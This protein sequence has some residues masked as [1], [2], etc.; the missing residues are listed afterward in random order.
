MG[1]ETWAVLVWG[2]VFLGGL[3]A[4]LGWL[5]ALASRRSSRR[6][7]AVIEELDAVGAGRPVAQHPIVEEA[8]CIGCGSCIAACPED[9][10][11]GLVD[12]IAHIIHGSHCVGHGRCAEACPVGAI[13]LG[14][15]DLSARPDLPVLSKEL[16]SSLPGIFLAGELGGL[17]LIRNAVR[18][19]ELAALAAA[20][21]A[22]T[23]RR[24]A[25]GPEA[26]D[27][28][29]VGAGPAG[30]TA[31]LKARELG[32]STLVLEQEEAGGTMRKYPRRKLVLTQPV[33]IPGLGELTRPEYSKEELLDLW[34]KALRREAL[35]I[36]ERVRLTGISGSAGAFTVRTSVGDYSARTVILALGRRGTPRRLGVPGEE[37]DK[38]FYQLIDAASY[39]GEHLLVVGGGDSAVEAAMALANQR[40]NTVTLSYRKPAFQRIKRRNAERIAEYQ[41]G[42][43]VEVIFSS[44][45]ER[46]EAD[47]VLL[48][49]EGED[50][51]REIPN[52]QVFIFAGGDPPFP[53]LREIGIRFGGD[54]EPRRA[55]SPV[56]SA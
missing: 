27:I 23:S 4:V 53:L 18:Q 34:E 29:V 22:A 37:L 56:V 35:P 40:G 1:D 13:T 9:D 2:A 25:P 54:S 41:G 55:A 21:R 48:R 8:R 45:V 20:R 30:L 32:A 12:G 31:A 47:S 33:K 7:R 11:L 36:L 14:L 43:R 17:A 3:L 44:Q 51:V 39:V 19:G 38:V 52:Q 46:I 28:L 49:V 26:V 50:A 42:G 10:V 16:E 15:G 5:Q 24:G 6:A